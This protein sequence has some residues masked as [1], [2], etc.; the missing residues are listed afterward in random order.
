M[1]SCEFWRHISFES[2]NNQVGEVTVCYGWSSALSNPY[3]P[4]R[5][6]SPRFPLFSGTVC[7]CLALPWT[8]A[9][10]T[11]REKKPK[12]HSSG[13]LSLSDL[14]ASLWRFHWR[15]FDRHFDWG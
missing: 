8:P 10:S 5:D 11:P 12:G 13:P 2:V 15:R 3:V 9:W 14:L 7:G 4:S 6:L 1:V